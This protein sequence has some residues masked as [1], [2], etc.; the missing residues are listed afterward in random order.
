MDVNDDFCEKQSRVSFDTEL[1]ETYFILVYGHSDD[2]DFM[3]N[4]ATEGEV[5][6]DLCKDAPTLRLNTAVV[7]DNIFA[8]FDFD[9]PQNC[10]AG[11]EI[12]GPTVWYKVC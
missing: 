12:T 2:G 3:L 9:S 10:D 7:G 1:G 11:I 5:Y 6:N 8:H 4:V